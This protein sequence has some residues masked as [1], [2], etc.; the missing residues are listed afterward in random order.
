M[1]GLWKNFGR[2]CVDFEVHLEE[3]EPL[4]LVHASNFANILRLRARTHSLGTRPIH[5]TGPWSVSCQALPFW[6]PSPDYS[7]PNLP[8]PCSGF[9][10]D[11]LR[12]SVF[13]PKYGGKR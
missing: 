10:R 1:R 11:G 8:V 6:L 13:V 12:R 2:T 9:Q 3:P 5:E 7:P 4:E